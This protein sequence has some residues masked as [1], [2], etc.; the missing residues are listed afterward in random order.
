MCLATGVSSKPSTRFRFDQLMSLAWKVLIPMALINLV[1]VMVVEEF[2][3]SRWLLLPISLA[4]LIG[5]GMIV[6]A[7]PSPPKRTNHS[8]SKPEQREPVAV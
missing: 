1:A 8:P 5:S 7:P 3:L 6:S 2:E 4:V